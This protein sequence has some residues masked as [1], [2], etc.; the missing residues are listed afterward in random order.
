MVKCHV[1]V[2]GGSN[3]EHVCGGVDTHL[4]VVLLYRIQNAA[5]FSFTPSQTDFFFLLWYSGVITN[6]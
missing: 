2:T 4:H 5:R 6:H 3:G 1:F